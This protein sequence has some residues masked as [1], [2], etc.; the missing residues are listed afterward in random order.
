MINREKHHTGASRRIQELIASRYV[1]PARRRGDKT[2]RVVAGDVA[3]EL[4]LWSRVPQVCSAMQ[5]Q[6]FLREQGLEIVGREGPQSG[7]STTVAITYQLAGQPPQAAS[8]DAFQALY[9]L[10]KKEFAEAGGGE[11]WLRRERAA[12]SDEPEP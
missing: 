3:R 2:V 9:G 10:F 1:E 8:G 12:W 7:L 4:Q 6:R 5:M 11:A